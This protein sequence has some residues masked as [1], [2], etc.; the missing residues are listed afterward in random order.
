MDEENENASREI[1]GRR[2]EWVKKKEK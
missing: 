1:G 2:G